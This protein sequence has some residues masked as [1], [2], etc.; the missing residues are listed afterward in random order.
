MFRDQQFLLHGIVD[1]SGGADDRQLQREVYLRRLEIDH[2]HE[3][4]DQLEHHVQNR[5][6]IRLGP[7][8]AGRRLR[9]ER[10]LR[11]RV[12]DG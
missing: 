4:G 11:S 1:R 8:R 9:H 3:E 2:Q 7:D 10:R 5:R 12:D 6:E